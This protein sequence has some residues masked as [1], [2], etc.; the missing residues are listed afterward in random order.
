MH[1]LYLALPYSLLSLSYVIVSRKFKAPALVLFLLNLCPLIYL[2]V[3]FLQA[4]YLLKLT[5]KDD[6][7]DWNG[8]EPAH[9]ELQEIDTV[10][11]VLLLIVIARAV[12]FVKITLLAELA[13][14]CCI[15]I[16]NRIQLNNLS[17]CNL[18]YGAI[19]FG[20]ILGAAF[21]AINVWVLTRHLKSEEFQY[22]T[23][24]SGLL[25]LNGLS[26]HL[27]FSLLYCTTCASVSFNTFGELLFPVLLYASAVFQN[28]AESFTEPFKKSTISL[29]HYLFSH[30]AYLCFVLLFISKI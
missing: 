18:S 9:E 6:D 27:S 11:Y 17:N 13:W 21:T 4:Q 8:G 16:L 28:I 12:T 3:C 22:Q 23:I 29:M 20:L 19:I 24:V 25:M 26:V 14:I 15:G 2:L 10:L 7:E 30:S 1:W 5:L